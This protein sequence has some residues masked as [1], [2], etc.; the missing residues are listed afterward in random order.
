MKQRL[1]RPLLRS[2]RLVSQQKN[3][4]LTVWQPKEDLG[5]LDRQATVR[6]K[7]VGQIRPLASGEPGATPGPVSP[8]WTGLGSISDLLSEPFGFQ[9]KLGPADCFESCI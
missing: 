3:W 1:L 2:H 5:D 7:G 6:A 4:L 8:H 9:P